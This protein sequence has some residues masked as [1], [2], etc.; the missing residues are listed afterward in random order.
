M[1]SVCVAVLDVFLMLCSIFYL[2][3]LSSQIDVCAYFSVGTFL[4]D[5]V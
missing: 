5:I 3:F 4:L 1:N 2:F